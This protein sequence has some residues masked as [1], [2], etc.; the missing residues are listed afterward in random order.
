LTKPDSICYTLFINERHRSYEPVS[1]VAGH[2]ADQWRTCRMTGSPTPMTEDLKVKVSRMYYLSDI[3]KTEIGKRLGISRF[4]V[5]RLLEQ[6]RQEEIVRIEVI[7]P[8]TSFADLEE[9]LEERFD[10]HHAVVVNMTDQSSQGSMRAIG[11][12]AAERMT[13]LLNDGDVLGITWGA[14]VNEVVKALPSKIDMDLQV[15]QT[16]GGLNQM[17]ISVNAMDLARRVA[18]IYDARC[19]ALHAPVMVNNMTAREVLLQDNG[20]RETVD[21][22]EKV[23]VALSGIG[24]FSSRVVSNLLM[25]GYFSEDDLT[26]L[27]DRKV[28][29]DI[30]AHFFNIHGQCC[31]PEI[32]KRIIG[33]SIDQLKAVR[34]SIGVAAGVHKSLAILGAL[35]GK[36]INIL[37]TD[38]ATALDILEK[39]DMF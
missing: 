2:A 37:I 38:Y 39:D 13:N 30:Y 24:A 4:R 12:A 26:R 7:E 9:Q 1:I 16:V 8:V 29:G 6:A 27:K 31:D 34:Y 3:S 36:L 35:R 19:Y 5:S 22:F 25:T 17:A 23:T 18:A 14:T 10:L 15:V 20:I 33:M 32:E 28:V 21:M 11:V